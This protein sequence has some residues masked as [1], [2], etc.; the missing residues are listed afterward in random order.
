[1]GRVRPGYVTPEDAGTGR[2]GSS[3]FLLLKYF[4]VSSVEDAEQQSD[5]DRDSGKSWGSGRSPPSVVHLLMRHTML[6][7]ISCIT[8]TAKLVW[9]LS[10]HVRFCDPGVVVQG[11]PHSFSS[12]QHLHTVHNSAGGANFYIPQPKSFAP[13]TWPE[14]ALYNSLL[15]SFFFLS[16]FLPSFLPFFVFFWTGSHCAI[17][18]GI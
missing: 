7:Y 4:L 6:L 10:T 16:P 12:S 14:I 15:L 3:P 11:W 9:T 8:T 17:Q 5:N 18:T 13:V 2:Q 1:M